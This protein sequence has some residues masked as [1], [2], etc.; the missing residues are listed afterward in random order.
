MRTALAP[1]LLAALMAGGCA[2]L[3]GLTKPRVYLEPRLMFETVD[4][5]LA[6]QSAS[7]NGPVTNPGLS[8]RDSFNFAHRDTQIGGRVHVG[9]GHS[10]FTAEVIQQ[11]F[12]SRA[13]QLLGDFGDLSGPTTSL[14]KSDINGLR[15][16]L[17]YHA[18]L[19]TVEE[20]EDL[21][22]RFSLGGSIE[23]EEVD[24]RAV[25]EDQSAR[26]KIRAHDNGIPM[27]RGRVDAEIQEFGARFDLGWS[28]G[29]WGDVSG[30][31]FDIEVTLR[32]QINE[33]VALLAGY[34]WLDVPLEGYEGPLR[35]D[36]DLRTAGYFVAAR[37]RF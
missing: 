7:A 3:P 15:A 27:A 36:L 26:Q 14:V 23:H 25:R 6:M 35:Y 30:P 11:D 22:L 21:R 19:W 29:D 4:G 8:S 1:G 32:Y 28:D 20:T 24:F 13:G 33:G 10:G 2:A 17:A 18:V 12:K 34:R 16:G 5:T 9:D 37:L 31:M